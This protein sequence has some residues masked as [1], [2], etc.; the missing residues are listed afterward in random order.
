MFELRFGLGD[1]VFLLA[2]N[3]FFKTKHYDFSAFI[4]NN[5]KEDAALYCSFLDDQLFNKEVKRVQP[6]LAG[7]EIAFTDSRHTLYLQ[8]QKLLIEKYFAD[9][10]VTI[11]SGADEYIESYNGYNETYDVENKVLANLSMLAAQ[12]FIDYNATIVH[13]AGVVKDGNAYIFLAEDEGGKTTL[14][15]K[16]REYHILN[17]DQIFFRVGDD[18]IVRADGTPF[19]RVTDGPC[20]TRVKA[21]FF[22]KKSHQHR[23]T[24][25]NSH[26]L[27]KSFLIDNTSTFSS[28]PKSDKKKAFNLLYTIANS[29]PVFDLE[30]HYGQIDWAYL[31]KCCEEV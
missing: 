23:I 10:Y 25:N 17:D 31:E 8:K 2:C 7:E 29:A 1:L 6:F 19:G 13:G 28:L 11:I 30:T 22:I 12:M 27:L 16:N 4:R 14:V 24:K 21:F 20:F 15:Q 9:H 5:H 3:Q 18:G 26:E